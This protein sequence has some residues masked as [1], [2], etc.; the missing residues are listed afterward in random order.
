MPPPRA[1]IYSDM[2]NV[3]VGPIKNRQGELIGAEIRPDA[4]W[5]LETLSRYGDVALL[6]SANRT[7]ANYV[8][9]E[10]GPAAKF[11]KNVYTVEDLYPVALALEM[12]DRAGLSQRDKE[13]LYGQVAP[14]LSPGVVFDDYPV[15]SWMYWLKGLATGIANINPRMWIEVEP[16]EAGMRDRGGLRRAFAEFLNRNSEWTGGRSLS[17]R[18]RVG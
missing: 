10:L 5:F 3:L 9:E 15:G 16:F 7:W 17:G 13:E 14:I 6:T 18:R 8:L 11:L 12:I 4:A 1:P 2:D